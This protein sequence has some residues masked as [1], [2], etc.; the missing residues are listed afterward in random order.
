MSSNTNRLARESS[1]YLRQH[2]TNPVDWYPWSEEAFEQARRKNLPVFLSIGYSTCH[3]CHIMAE[4]SFEDA[5]IANLLNSNFIPVKVDREERPD[6][7]EFYMEV[8]QAM[9]GSGGWPLTIIMTPEKKPFFAATY[10]PKEAAMGQMGLSDLLMQVTNIWEYKRDEIRQQASQLVSEINN[11]P[12]GKEPVSLSIL[13]DAFSA[14]LGMFDWRNGGFGPAPKFPSPSI[15]IFLLNRWK[16]DERPQTLK[17]IENTLSSMADGGIYDHLGGGF[18]R[19]STDA[20]WNIPHF[21]KMLYDQAMLVVVYL[22]AYQATGNVHYRAV[23]DSTISY[24]GTVLHHPEGGFYCG[25]DADSEGQEGLFYLWSRGQIEDPVGKENSDFFLHFYDIIPLES[26]SEN[27]GVLRRNEYDINE[28][29][30]AKLKEIKA[31]L[32][33]LRSER[34][35]PSLDNKIL[36]D[37]NGFAIAALSMASRICGDISALEKAKEAASFIFS[38]M[39]RDDG[40]LYHRFHE[41]NSG[42]DGFLDDYAFLA[43]GLIELY[44]AT[45]ETKYLDTAI[46]IVDMMVDMFYDAEQ[47][48]FFFSASDVSDIP[49]RTKKVFD[50]PYP[51]GNSVAVYNLF[52]LFHITGNVRYRELGRETLSAFGGM[53]KRSPPA[54]SYMLTGLMLGVESNLVVIV[55]DSGKIGF[56]EMM[57]VV[58]KNYLPKTILLL[59]NPESA[60][61]LARIAPY[62]LDMDVKEGRTTA[63]VC[64]GQSCTPPVNDPRELESLLF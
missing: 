48:G 24:M 4:E 47:G 57:D 61:D 46:E 33:S 18:H 8:C 19:Y 45:F 9:N 2:S 40:R 37:W 52:W 22:M 56:K 5:Q 7:D 55:T 34:I 13:E 12:A 53:L 62:T 15:L 26:E 49:H 43:W 17:M 64:K 23:A 21:E 27:A 44:E 39:R 38:C 29:S 6:V 3:W 25:E 1:P 20:S 54:Y 31:H 42:I 30:N 50:G 63:Y 59:K 11:I 28:T 16:T 32:L 51:S 58:R 36:T 60:R 10:I 35:R 14:L 41:G